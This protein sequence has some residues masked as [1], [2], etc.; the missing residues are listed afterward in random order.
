MLFELAIV[1]AAS[2]SSGGVAISGAHEEGYRDGAA[3]ARQV[4]VT[5]WVLLGG[6]ASLLSSGALIPCVPPAP[7]LVEKPATTI[8]G[9]DASRGE[10]Y[11]AGYRKGFEQTLHSRRAV[12]GTVSA[13]IVGTVLAAGLGIVQYVRAEEDAKGARGALPAPPPALFRF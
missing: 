6:G 4:P 5:D 11:A 12:A 1:L 8:E 7:F 10:E 13:V 9:L 2:S 3:E